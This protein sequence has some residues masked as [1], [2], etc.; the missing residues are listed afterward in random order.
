MKENKIDFSKA[1]DGT[2]FIY[3]KG[4]FNTPFYLKGNLNIFVKNMP[5]T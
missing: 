2:T 1:G 5:D 4:N 3:R